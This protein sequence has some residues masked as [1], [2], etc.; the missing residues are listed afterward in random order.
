MKKEITDSLIAKWDNVLAENKRVMAGIIF[1]RPQRPVKPS[2][3][4]ETGYP[5]TVDIKP[6]RKYL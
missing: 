3:A 6:Q 5:Y 2:N 1:E 4:D